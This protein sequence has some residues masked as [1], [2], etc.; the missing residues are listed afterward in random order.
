M[1]TDLLPKREIVHCRGCTIYLYTPCT[2]VYRV[3]RP[4][5]DINMDDVEFIRRQRFTWTK[6]A[7]ILGVSRTSLY[8]RL[9][10][11]IPPSTTY[12]D[13]S[14]QQLDQLIHQI[15]VDHPHDG[16]RL[17]IGHLAHCS[18]IVPRASIHR[19][20]PENTALRRSIAVRRRVY[21][22]SGPNAVWHIDGNHKLIRW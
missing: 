18:V 10:E 3:G 4:K 5:V 22:A 2:V 12:S 8:H 9:D 17:M 7:V 13:I 19:V 21:H 15:K 16:E 1:S 11:G 6:I 20:D 14:D